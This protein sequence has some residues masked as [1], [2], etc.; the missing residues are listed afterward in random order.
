LTG[1][2]R[3]MRSD[4]VMDVGRSINPAID[5]GQIEGAFIQGQ[6]WSTI[7]ELIWGDRQHPW[8]RPGTMKTNGPGAYKIPCTDD[9][10]RIFNV[11]LMRDT[12]N[13]VAVHSSRAIGEPPLYLGAST[14]W[15]VKKAITAARKD[16]G[17]TEYYPLDLPLTSERIRMACYDSILASLPQNARGELKNFR[18]KGSF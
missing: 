3:S 6:G 1:D 9:I 8:V 5:I 18:A 15:A 10:P 4:L 13:P 16:A 7:E 11:T 14:Y 12:D 17:M 2:H